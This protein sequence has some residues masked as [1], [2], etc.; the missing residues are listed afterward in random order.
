MPESCFAE[1]PPPLLPCSACPPVLAHWQAQAILEFY[2]SRQRLSP[3]R[4]SLALF[5]ELRK[6]Q[7][8]AGREDSGLRTPTNQIIPRKRGGASPL[9]ADTANPAKRRDSRRDTVVCV[10]VFAC[11]YVCMC[12]HVC[13]RVCD[14]VAGAPL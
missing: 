11:E 9:P 2:H 6:G 12:L 8:P 1:C 7:A 5:V 4:C 14:Q 3:Y 10:H 13:M